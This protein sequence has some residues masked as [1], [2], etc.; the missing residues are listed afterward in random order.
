[1]RDTT[2]LGNYPNKH[3]CSKH[4]V[5]HVCNFLRRVCF[6]K[7]YS[8]KE[9]TLTVQLLKLVGKYITFIMHVNIILACH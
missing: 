6:I 3:I 2:F 8:N 5:L 7:K 9:E 1:M 4:N